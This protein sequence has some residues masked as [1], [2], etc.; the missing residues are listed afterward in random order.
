MGCETTEVP[1]IIVIHNFYTH[2]HMCTN[3]RLFDFN[4][5]EA[6]SHRESRILGLDCSQPV[7]LL[8]V[9]LFA[10]FWFVN[11]TT[12]TPTVWQA[13]PDFTVLNSSPAEHL[14]LK[15]FLPLHPLS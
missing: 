8:Q 1:I 12:Q 15:I 11:Q 2:T 9:S 7:S 10:I 6:K 13:N 5:L 3:L 4:V 14:I